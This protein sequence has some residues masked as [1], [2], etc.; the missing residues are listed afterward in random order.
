[1]T[2]PKMLQPL[3]VGLLLLCVLG[4]ATGLTSGRQPSKPVE[5]DAS[6]VVGPR[7][8]AECH[9]EE[10]RT[11]LETG[12][13]QGFKTLARLPEARAMSKALGIRRLKR[14]ARCIGCHFTEQWTDENQS[15]VIAGVS[16]ES[17]HGAGAD[18]LDSHADYG[19]DGKTRA[20][21]TMEHKVARLKAC[22]ESGMRGP[23]NLYELAARCYDCHLMVDEELHAAGHSVG[24]GFELGT[25]LQGKVRHNFVRGEGVNATASLERQR[26][27]FLLGTL[28]EVQ[29]TMR[30]VES[31]EPESPIASVVVERARLGRRALVNV[32]GLIAAPAFEELLAILPEEEDLVPRNPKLEGGAQAAERVARWLCLEGDGAQ[33]GALDEL[34]Q[35]AAAKAER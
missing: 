6:S 30:A 1:M 4:L 23:A 27:L 31:L 19:K 22:A 26:V 5:A 17:C 8:C 20:T 11:W 35:E 25:A 16:C 32:A 21:E 24:A 14:E 13:H 9:E 34:V 28:L 10:N 29:F 18:W 33:F 15:K 7:R 2:R 12:H 3:G